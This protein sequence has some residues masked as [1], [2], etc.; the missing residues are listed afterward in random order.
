[1]FWEYKNYLENTFR[2]LSLKRNANIARRARDFLFTITR[3]I[4]VKKK[5]S[6]TLSISY[7]HDGYL[8]QI[9][10]YQQFSKPKFSA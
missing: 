10:K 2:Y 5:M 6:C 3:S 4:F 1:M 7:Y 8:F 9:Y